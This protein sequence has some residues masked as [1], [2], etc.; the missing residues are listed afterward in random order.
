MKKQRNLFQIK[1][2]ERKKKLGGKNLIKHIN[3]LGGKQF[4]A[5]I[6]ILAKLGK[7]ISEPSEHLFFFFSVKILTRN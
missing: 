1:E 2:Q 3:N 6:I 4:K 7:R 5:L